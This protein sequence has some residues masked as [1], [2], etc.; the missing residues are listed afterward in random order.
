MSKCEQRQSF[1]KT[2][3]ALNYEEL[4]VRKPR[5]GILLRRCIPKPV[6]REG[7]EIVKRFLGCSFIIFGNF[8]TKGSK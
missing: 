2:H 5:M 1:A 3:T 7:V 6:L 4:K 8:T